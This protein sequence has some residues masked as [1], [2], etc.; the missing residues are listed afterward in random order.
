MVINNTLTNNTEVRE[1]SVL[2]A[3]LQ[4]QLI[5]ALGGNGSVV[6]VLPNVASSQP[7]SV[8]EEP[9]LVAVPSVPAKEVKQSRPRRKVVRNNVKSRFDGLS[10][11]ELKALAKSPFLSN[12]VYRLLA[13]SSVSAVLN[14]LSYNG[15][16]TIDVLLLLRNN[17]KL[18]DCIRAAVDKR[19]QHWVDVFTINFNEDEAEFINAYGQ[20]NYDGLVSLLTTTEGEAR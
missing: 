11:D 18:A 6:L 12:E 16:L 19:L 20:L 5:N 15:C 14:S 17:A 1:I 2:P 10:S 13:A 4:Q 9:A 7:A 3:E 8:E